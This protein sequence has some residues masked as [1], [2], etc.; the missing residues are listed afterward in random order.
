MIELHYASKEFFHSD[1]NIFM[2]VLGTKSDLVKG[3]GRSF[4]RVGSSSTAAGLEVNDF[5]KDLDA[6]HQEIE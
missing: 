2:Q 4:R 1:I 5:I 6:T 3:L